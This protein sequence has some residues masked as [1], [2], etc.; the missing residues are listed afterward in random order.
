LE[1]PAHVDNRGAPTVVKEHTNGEV[2]KKPVTAIEEPVTNEN[3][4]GQHV[5]K[6]I[7]ADVVKNPGSSSSRSHDARLPKFS[8]ASAAA[9]GFIDF[10]SAFD[11]AIAKIDALKI[12][13][14]KLEVQVQWRE[15]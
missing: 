11:A 7:V 9:E 4:I 5:L 12:E 15:L 10:D 2:R 14:I 13:K 8:W 1:P 3:A 6:P